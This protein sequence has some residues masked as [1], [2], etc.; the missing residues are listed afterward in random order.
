MSSHRERLRALGGSLRKGFPLDDRL[1]N[2]Q[3]ESL[4]HKLA[5]VPSTNQRKER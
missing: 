4:L 5:R 1:N 3:F 2:R